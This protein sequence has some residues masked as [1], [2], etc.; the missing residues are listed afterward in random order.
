MASSTMH[1][2]SSSRTRSMSPSCSSVR[3]FVVINLAI[4]L[5]F[6][7]VMSAFH[8]RISQIDEGSKWVH[9]LPCPPW[10]AHAYSA[11]LAALL[12]FLLVVYPWLCFAPRPPL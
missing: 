7:G 8:L 9:C 12:G 2:L 6:Y 1:L 3:L 10:F 11:A 4:V 5:I